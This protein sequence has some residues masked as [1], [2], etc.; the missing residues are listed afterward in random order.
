MVDR[1]PQIRIT[2]TGD[3][4]GYLTVTA[5]TG[6]YPGATGFLTQADGTGMQLVQVTDVPLA[7]TIGVKF[8]PQGIDDEKLR[9]GAVKYP[10]YGRTDIAAYTAGAILTLLAQVVPVNQDGTRLT[11]IY[12]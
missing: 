11:S 1:V 5:N 2:G 12:E 3:A 4:N 7:T 10:W 6:V 8:L 9:T